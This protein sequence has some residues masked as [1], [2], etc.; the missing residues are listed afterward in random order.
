MQGAAQS[1]RDIP[2][3]APAGEVDVRA[4]G[5][6][7]WAK[8]VFIIGPTLLVAAIAIYA[9]GAIT[10]KYLSEARI[11][12][13]TSENA[14]TRPAGT[15]RDLEP[16]A[17]ELAV[18]S[19][20]QLLLSR[21]LAAAVVQE[22]DL[23]SNAEFVGT[24]HTS[25][26]KRV[27]VSLGLAR[28]PAKM[29]DEERA[30]DHYY[31]KLTVFAVDKSRVITAQF[32]AEDPVL[33]ARVANAV[34]ERYLQLQQAAKQSTTQ[35][36]SNWLSSQIA[37]LSR[38]VADAE[39]KVENYRSTANLYVGTGTSTLSAQQLNDLSNDLS[40]AVSQQSEAQTKADALKGALASG[41]PVESLDVANSELIRRLAEQRVALASSIARDARTYL[42]GHPRMKELNAQLS[43]LDGQ[44]RDEARKI[45][46]SYENEAS[47]AASRV[48]NIR[49]TLDAQK[50]VAGTA[51]AQEVQ[52]R[53]LEREARAQRELLEQFLTRFRDAS[54]REQL[55][56]IPSDARIISRA[57]PASAPYSPKPLPTIAL[58]T[59]GTFVLLVVGITASEFML[60]PASATGV[61][62]RPVDPTTPLTDGPVP[63]RPLDTETT[64]T[65]SGRPV[66]DRSSGGTT[67]LAGTR[68]MEVEAADMRMLGELAAQLSATP[69]GEGALNILTISSAA[70]IDAGGIALS[71]ARS[72][73]ERGRKS[74]VVDAG[75]E[76][77]R[78]ADALSKTSEAGLGDL[79]AGDVS[80]A[81]AIQRDR[82]SPAHLIGYGKGSVITPASLQ[83]IGIV[84]DALGL[85]YDFVIVLAPSSEREE[86]MKALAKRTGAAILV[87]AG[88]TDAATTAAHN[89]L[90]AA[91]VSDV[92][93]LVTTEP[94]TGTYGD[95]KTS[96]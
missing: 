26:V 42:P 59:L 7:L 79:M 15:E 72:L 25:A 87:S 84:F 17:D 50:K 96:A 68:E 34:A 16:A 20:V 8:K 13:E 37:E 80:F 22:L 18:Q 85:T 89:A 3:T 93:V 6:S 29:T 45:A 90:L 60:V 63:T 32:T 19:Q 81:D 47:I 30:L 31:E 92:V 35:Q 28:D 23:K 27:L 74:V 11:L 33:A 51:S 61:P 5:R 41:R 4:I 43:S 94:T 48:T 49:A 57:A 21:D 9:V 36:A 2:R 40:R 77:P 86:E 56:S 83:R 44:V 52:L 55:G 82:A 65:G 73:A 95:R 54:A 76:S 24:G 10:P 14:Y 78:F 70:G 67:A 1:M 58:S 38:R 53:A 91:G 71:L 62:V 46:R 39:A 64:A 75:R 66:F 12:V 69:R 88:S